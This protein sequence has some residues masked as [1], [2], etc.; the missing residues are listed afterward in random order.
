MNA[1]ILAFTAC[2]QAAPDDCRERELAF[3]AESLTVLQCT[4]GA[5]IPLSQWA[6]QHPKWRVRDYRCL[7]S[8]EREVAL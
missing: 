7:T 3:A 6:D 4:M 2:L 5:H 1:I 8:D